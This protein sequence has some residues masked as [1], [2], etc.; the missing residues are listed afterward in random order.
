MADN[1]AITITLKLE[2]EKEDLDAQKS[3]NTSSTAAKED[4]DST[5]KA[6]AAFAVSQAAQTVASE[7]VAWAEYEWNKELTL[8]DDYIGQREKNIALAQ[9]NRGISV[10]SGIA[11][12]TASGA[13]VGGWIGAIIGFAI[14]TGTQIAGIARSNIQGQEQQSIHIRQMDAQLDFTRSRAGWSTEAASIGENL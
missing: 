9:I 1:R 3:V 8:N 7:V 13:A 14:G 11:S 12:A 2:S 5:A 10:V 4:N 6:I